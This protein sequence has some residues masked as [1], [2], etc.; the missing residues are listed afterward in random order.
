MNINELSVLV[1]E[2]GFPVMMESY[3]EEPLVFPLLCDV[4]PHTPAQEFG[5][6]STVIIGIGDFREKFSGQ[7]YEAD[8]LVQGPEFFMRVREFGRML[9]LDGRLVDQARATAP[10]EIGDLIAAA[11]E[12]AGRSARQKKEQLVAGMFQKGTL[13]AGSAEHFDGTFVEN[14]AI[15]QDPHPKYIYDGKPWFSGAHPITIGADTFSNHDASLSL[16]EDNYNTVRTRM[17]MSNNRNERGQHVS[18]RPDTILV[19]SGNRKPALQIVGSELQPGGANNDV[20]VSRGTAAVI[21]WS[22]LDDA[23]SASAWWVGQRGRG[24]KARDSG[25]P[26][27][28][29]VYDPL[30]NMYYVVWSTKF[31]A[32]VNDWRYWNCSNKVAA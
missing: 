32:A 27:Q 13:T 24:I 1:A 9:P 3:E 19:P 5:Y 11:A 22:Y 10:G 25:M 28:R 23:A 4:E 16:T 26:T 14:N 29:V 31:G 2:A 6:K 21:T 30:K 17:Q 7:E 15:T 12:S 8:E 18:I 20:N